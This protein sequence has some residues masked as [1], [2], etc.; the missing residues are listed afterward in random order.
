VPYDEFDEVDGSEVE[1]PEDVENGNDRVLTES[2]SEDVDTE[3]QVGLGLYTVKERR[4]K[5]DYIE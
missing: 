3:H 2:D 1:L 4:K 5:K